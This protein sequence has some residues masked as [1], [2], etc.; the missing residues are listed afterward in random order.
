[1][2]KALVI[3]G[4]GSKG[5][6]A[7]GVAEFLL[8]KFKN[9]SL[10]V[11]S[12]TGSLL[13]PLL[14]IGKINKLKDIYSNVCQHHIF[15]SNPFK[16]KRDVQ[17]HYVIK[18]NHL[19]VLL[20]FIKGR[21]TF[22]ESKNL[23]KIIKNGYTAQDHQELIK[24]GKSVIVTVSNL[25]TNEVEYK[26]I[27]TYPYEDA[28]DWIW[29]SANVVPFMSLLVKNGY[30]YADGGFGTTA[31]TQKAIDEGC[32]DIDAII[33]EN[34]DKKF[35]VPPSING[36]DLLVKVLSFSTNQLIKNDI[37]IANLSAL[38]KKVH[39]H[40]FFPPRVLT[41]N[42]LVFEPSQ[43]KQWWDDG[44]QYAKGNTPKK[45]IIENE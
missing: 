30:E 20:Q 29:A 31:P 40:L 23:Y 27:E 25:T 14:A 16:I 4:G 8:S 32:C 28:L 18:I 15:S 17:G 12:S 45:L 44:Y 2:K 35:H 26:K 1:M 5:A 41:Y 21:K 3:S 10:F 34:Q 24:S 42:A 37:S 13:V 38:H 43:M 9:Y 39:L 33:L 7:G 19:K 11:G 22:G 36:F 6:F